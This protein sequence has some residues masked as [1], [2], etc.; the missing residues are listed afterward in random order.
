MKDN[1]DNCTFV[2]PNGQFKPMKEPYTSGEKKIGL[3]LMKDKTEH[4]EIEYL[5]EK[6]PKGK[7][8]LRGEAMVL[9]T[10]ARKQA[11]Q[12]CLEDEIKFLENWINHG[13]YN[14][15]QKRLEELKAKVGK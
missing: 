3:D 10:L 7:C 12:T 6:F 8:K 4:P 15:M 2:A 9:L 5:D 11:T 14:D 1:L 13:S